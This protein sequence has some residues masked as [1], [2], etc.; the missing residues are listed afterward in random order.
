VGDLPER[1]VHGSLVGDSLSTVTPSNTAAFSIASS[2]FFNP[3]P[4]DPGCESPKV[5][6]RILRFERNPLIRPEDVHASLPEATV[7]CVLNP[8]AFFHQG[9]I[10]LLMRVAEGVPGDEYY[11]RSLVIEKDGVVRSREFSR[12]DP[13]FYIPIIG[14]K[15]DP[16]VFYYKDV[17]YLTTLSHLRLAKSDD[18]INFKIEDSPTLIGEGPLET[19]GIEDCRVT[20]IEETY[21]ITYTAVSKSGV[22]VGLRSTKDWLKFTHHGIILPPDNK[23]CSLFPAKIGKL[24]YAI[25]RP[26]IGADVG[27]VIWISQSP[28]LT[29]WGNHMPLM[30]ARPGQWD[31]ERIGGGDS[32]IYTPN[33]WL[34]IYHGVDKNHHYR[35]GAVLLD[36]DNPT[37]V[38]ARSDEPIMEPAMD[39]EQNGFFGNVVFTNGVLHDERTRSLLIYYGASDTVI[40]GARISLDVVFDS[41]RYY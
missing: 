35:L 33:G 20:Q 18:G 40:C 17:M 29:H 15:E 19:F 39:Y 7:E 22:A 11:A 31:S 8:G 34:E 30:E 38:L 6:D 1:F 14:S 12:S 24:Y 21:Y 4:S 25:H 26:M 28:D 3:I 10:C 13:E 5:S 37:R 23:D 9:K 2:S 32:P 41:L 36:L 16:R 27:R